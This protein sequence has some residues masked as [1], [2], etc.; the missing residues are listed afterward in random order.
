MRGKVFLVMWG[1]DD[2]C[3]ACSLRDEE[4]YVYVESDDGD[5]AFRLIRT[6]PPDVVVI[7]LSR[8]PSHGREGPR[9]LVKTKATRNLPL[10]LLGGDEETRAAIRAARHRNAPDP[11]FTSWDG[12]LAALAPFSRV[13]EGEG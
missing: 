1:A 12:L 9:S 2:D 11:I 4:W 13:D 5:L 10:I 7:D 8:R 3:R 6:D